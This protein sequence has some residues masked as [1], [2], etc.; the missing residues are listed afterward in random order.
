MSGGRSVAVTG[1]AGSLGRVLVG[2][3][4]ADPAIARVVAVD[5]AQA[6]GGNKIEVVTADVRDPEL[7][8]SFAGCDTVVHLAYIVE[9]GS[10]DEALVDAV[11]I[12]GTRNVAEAAA[13][14]GARQLVYASSIAAYGFHP[15]NLAGE[16]TEDAPVRGNDDFYYA[17]T[18]AACE[19]LLDAFEAAHPGVAVAR[20]R[21][22]I[23]LGPDGARSTE[24][25]K[26]RLFPVLG[27]R[28]HKVQL[29]HEDDV[30][31][32]FHLAVTRGARGAYNVATTEP[33]AM[34]EWPR[35]MGAWPIAVPE[36]AALALAD[37]AYRRRWSDV[38]PVWLRAGSAYPIVVSSAKIRR[39]LKWRPR[40]ETTGQVLRALAGRPAAAAN[41]GTKLLF[42]SL[43]AVTRVRGGLPM[44]E[45]ERKETRAING[46]ANLVFTGDTPSEWHLSFRDGVGV[47]A[48]LDPDA[49]ATITM[50]EQTFFDMLSGKL[51]FPR[52]QMTGKIRMR[53][54]GGFALVVGAIVGGFHRALGSDERPQRWFARLV[55]R[56]AGVEQ[57]DGGKQA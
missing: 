56:A 49:R 13:A 9:R 16:L 32:A 8:R 53:G 57:S 5:R 1:A 46:S 52:A 39:E 36:R 55:L 6:A 45:R 50:A 25:F 20:L 2:K 35:Q 19:R 23:F 11:N 12:G 30:A 24:R 28:E 18:K 31:E 22:T 42:G 29:T 14:A 27:R 7:A 21:P 44:S 4:A 37:L 10:R 26:K 15:D 17:R 51:T 3:L 40:Y 41:L 54:E 47:Y 48:G 38:D 34:A 33:L 43:A